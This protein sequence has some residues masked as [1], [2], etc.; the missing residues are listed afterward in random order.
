MAVH[1]LSSLLLIKYLI[2]IPGPAEC[3]E[4]LNPPPL[5]AGVSQT[6]PKVFQKKGF[7]GVRALRQGHPRGSKNL[8][9]VLE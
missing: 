5:G 6:L 8:G 7:Q 9:V 2:T 1:R 4:R 3:A